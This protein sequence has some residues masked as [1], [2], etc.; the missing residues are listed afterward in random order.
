MQLSRNCLPVAAGN[1]ANKNQNSKKKKKMSWKT[2]MCL[3]SPKPAELLPA[4]ILSQQSPSRRKRDTPGF[5]V[6]V[7]VCVGA[8]TEVERHRRV[9]VCFA[10]GDEVDLVLPLLLL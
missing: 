5:F 1:K 4:V 2:T 3:C 9:V 10:V 7:H 6:L 8:L